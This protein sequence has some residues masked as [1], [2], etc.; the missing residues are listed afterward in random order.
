MTVEWSVM[1]TNKIEVSK[2]GKGKTIY[3]P[4]SVYKT[5]AGSITISCADPKHRFKF[6]TTDAGLHKFLAKLGEIFDAEI[7]GGKP[8]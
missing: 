4:L 3:V 7:R 2:D 6:N 8:N 5:P 1:Q